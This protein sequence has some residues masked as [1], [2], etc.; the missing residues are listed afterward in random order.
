MKLLIA[1]Y[2][3]KLASCF[4]PR[5]VNYHLILLSVSRKVRIDLGYLEIAYKNFSSLPKVNPIFPQVSAVLSM[6]FK[7][8][9]G[10]LEY[11]EGSNL[12]KN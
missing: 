7:A 11:N 2:L 9:I 4:T 5:R 6:F 8:H 3:I 10:A 1:L 12:N